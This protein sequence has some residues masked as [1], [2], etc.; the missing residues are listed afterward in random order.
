[1]RNSTGRKVKRN[2]SFYTRV[3]KNITKGIN[4]RYRY[5]KMI[6]GVIYCG[7]TRTLREA[8]SRLATLA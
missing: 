1:M 5:N 2:A 8:K 6:D 3:T 7:T 4:G